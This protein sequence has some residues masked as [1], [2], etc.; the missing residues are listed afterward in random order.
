V[1]VSYF[2]VKDSG[3]T[4]APRD[5]S[6]FGAPIAAGDY[7]A[8]DYRLRDFK[9]SWNYLTYPVPPLDSKLRFKT[10]WE[11]QYVQMRP[12]IAFPISGGPPVTASERILYP[13]LGA[14]LDYVPSP[15][16]FRVDMRF[17]GFGLPGHAVLWDGEGS[18]VARIR[19]VEIFAGEKAFHF[20][21]SPGKDIFMQGTLWGPY[22]GLRWVFK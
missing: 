15:K 7:L 2:D 1:E 18:L 21:T 19:R 22:G 3:N 20:R 9:L 13:T 10:L 16:H 11:F 6:I 17:S 8:M 5:L 4:L 14:G 12:L